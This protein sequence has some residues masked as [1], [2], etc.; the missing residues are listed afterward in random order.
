[1][2]LHAGPAWARDTLVCIVT[3]RLPDRAVFE[4]GSEDTRLFTVTAALLEERLSGTSIVRRW[5]IV[6]DGPAQ[7]V[8]TSFPPATETLLINH[9]GNTFAESGLNTQVRGYCQTN[10]LP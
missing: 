8:A 3:D 4:T 2:L 7:L 9:D 5:T 1:M 10:D 6:A